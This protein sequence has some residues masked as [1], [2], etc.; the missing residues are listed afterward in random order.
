[1]RTV[2]VLVLVLLG[3]TPYPERPFI[4][5][6]SA[7]SPM[8]PGFTN[9]RFGMS[10]T[11][12]HAARPTVQKDDF[13]SSTLLVEKL[14]SNQT[15]ASVSYDVADQGLWRVTWS[16]SA[17]ADRTIASCQQVFETARQHWGEQFERKVG[18]IERHPATQERVRF[19]VV[20]WT[21]P[22]AHA[23]LTCVVSKSSQPLAPNHINLTVFVPNRKIE[24][25]VKTKFVEPLTEAEMRSVFE[26]VLPA[27]TR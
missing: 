8:L 24:T 21:T 20:V 4:H 3:L 16:R 27:A 26:V 18:V 2:A 13:P 9:L 22:Q 7:G 19:P 17:S 11:E 23:V 14:A 15:F 1:M 12:L 6:T 10:V 25:V 5:Q